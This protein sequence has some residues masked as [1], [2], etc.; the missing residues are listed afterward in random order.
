MK[1]L[2]QA[3]FTSP[4]LLFVFSEWLCLKASKEI[5][6]DGFAMLSLDLQEQFKPE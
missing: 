5:Y 1:D 2:R 4:G 6:T 3:K